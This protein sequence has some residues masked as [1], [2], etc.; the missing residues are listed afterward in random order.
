MTNFDCNTFAYQ[1]LLFK[2]AAIVSKYLQGGQ[3]N[4]SGEIIKLITFS[5]PTLPEQQKIS[6][7]LSILD[8]LI[9][10]QT[11]KI[12]TLKTH[13]KGMMQQLFPQNTNEGTV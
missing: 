1:F 12:A 2:Q 3:G 13:K 5:S 9:N 8:E 6:D 7:C 10:L 4:L 11:Q